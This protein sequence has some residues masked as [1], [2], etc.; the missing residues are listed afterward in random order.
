MSEIC[1]YFFCAVC[2]KTWCIRPIYTYVS[3]YIYLCVCVCVCLC[4]RARKGVSSY[5]IELYI[6]LKKFAV[7]VF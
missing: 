6:S 2:T 4:A 1:N 3:V 5:V 7:I